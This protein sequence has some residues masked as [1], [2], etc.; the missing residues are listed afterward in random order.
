LTE[1]CRVYDVPPVLIHET[2][3]QSSWAASVEALLQ[4][5]TALTLAPHCTS[6]EKEINSKLVSPIDNSLF[7]KFKMDALMKGDP[8]NRYESYKHGIL[9]GWN[10]IN[11]I[12]AME[13]LNPLP[14]ELGDVH[15]IPLNMQTLDNA[16][17]NKNLEPIEEEKET[18]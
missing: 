13:D 8:K 4:G 17:Q 9:N 5:F 6:F 1:I 15:F 7:V 3:K 10:T 18:E 16:V 12:R 2:T 11:E 14:P